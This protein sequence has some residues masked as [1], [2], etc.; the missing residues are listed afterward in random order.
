MAKPNVIHKQQLLQAAK[1]L[2]AERGMEK[3][4]LKAIAE[5]AN[6][7]QGTVYYHFKTKEQLLLEVTESFCQSAWEEMDEGFQVE[8]ALQSAKSRC[9]K[10]SVYHHLFFQLLASS[11]QNE[12]MRETIGEL[13][14]YENEKLQVRLQ[15]MWEKSPIEGITFETWSIMC[16]ALIDGLALQALYNPKFSTEEAY[17][18]VNKLIQHVGV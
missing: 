18:G 10:D 12:S 17:N 14:H 7:T 9:T 16:N 1:T 2:I 4:T 5:K 8:K 6:V 15:G 3:L 11:L 13:L